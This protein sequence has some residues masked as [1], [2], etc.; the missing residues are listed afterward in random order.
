MQINRSMDLI[1]TR[2]IYVEHA[3]FMYWN[4]IHFALFVTLKCVF[5]REC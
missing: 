4:I 3:K 1:D 2:I 5:R